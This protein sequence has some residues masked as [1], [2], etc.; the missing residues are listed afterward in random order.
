MAMCLSIVAFRGGG[1]FNIHKN[2][3]V[4]RVFSVFTDK[5]VN[6]I[7]CFHEIRLTCFQGVETP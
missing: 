4:V 2:K 3:V 5:I 1:A 6:I 7:L